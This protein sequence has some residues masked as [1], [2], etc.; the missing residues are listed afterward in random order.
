MRLKLSQLT[1]QPENIY[2]RM[3]V[4]YDKNENKV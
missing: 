3:A 4:R 1:E 2:Y